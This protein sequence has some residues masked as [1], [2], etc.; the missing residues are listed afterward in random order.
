MKILC[1]LHTHTLFCDGKNTPAEMAKAAFDKGFQT[2]GFS[3][4]SVLPWN[5]DWCMTKEQQEQYIKEVNA[6]KDEYKGKMEIVL[7]LELDSQSV[8]TMDE[9][10]RFSYIIGSVH[11]ATAPTGKFFYADYDQN[12]FKEAIDAFGG[13]ENFAEQYYNDVV[14]TAKKES[15]NILGHF[16]LFV[17]FNEKYNF[18]DESSKWYRDLSLSAAE[19]VAKTGV[20]VEVNSGAI[21]RHIKTFPYPSKDI[22]TRFYEKNVPIIISSDAHS[23]KYI[24]CFFDES[25]KLLQTIGFKSLVIYKD[26][27]FCEIKI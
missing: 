5:E 2:L 4:H 12:Q 23:T 18:F 1:N 17:K 7:G 15:T 11:A 13:I 14:L 6:H 24:D 21:A 16:D 8:Y 10:S 19:E 26:G 22:L 25:L 27:K 9:L 3:G 20:I